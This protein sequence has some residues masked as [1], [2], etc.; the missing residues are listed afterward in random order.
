[1]VEQVSILAAIKRLPAAP[2]VLAR[3]L[4]IMNDPKAGSQ[5]LIDAIEIDPGVTAN[6]LRMCNSPYYGGSRQLSSL[7]EAVHRLGTRQVMQL[8]TMGEGEALLGGEHEGY[9]LASGD[10]WQ[11]SV[12]TALAARLLGMR[13]GHPRV[14]LLFTGGL[15]HDLGKIALDLYLKDRYV[16]VRQ[17]VEMGATFQEAESQALGIEHAELGARIAENWGFPASLV[18]MIRFHHNPDMA[19]EDQDLCSLIH[20]SNALAQWLGLG[21]GRPGLASRFESSAVHRFNLTPADL[22]RILLELVEKL[23]ETQSSLAA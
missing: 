5:D 19:D 11:H 12:S 18:R 21:L 13:V 6:L 14:S 9:G 15:L 8:V 16:E 4:M 22:D 2:L 7:Q 23:D 3:V 1:M 17:R 10:L 20:L